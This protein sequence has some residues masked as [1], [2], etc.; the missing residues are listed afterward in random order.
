MTEGN[1]LFVWSF[2][3]IKGLIAIEVNPFFSG[4]IKK[5]CHCD[6]KPSAIAF[7]VETKI[8]S[9]PNKV[10][11]GR[12]LPLKQAKVIQILKNNRRMLWGKGFVSGRFHM[13]FV[14]KVLKT[15]S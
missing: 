4:V 10:Q 3:F 1:T 9:A 6:Q 8:C 2:N 14:P 7:F 12:R 15:I 5:I 11:W 13:Q